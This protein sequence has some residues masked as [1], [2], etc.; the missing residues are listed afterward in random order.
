MSTFYIVEEEEGSSQVAIHAVSPSS[1]TARGAA[2]AAAAGSYIPVDCS[3]L[4]LTFDRCL[5][6]RHSLHTQEGL[7]S[8][9]LFRKQCHHATIQL[10]PCL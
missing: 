7:L 6:L 9:H 4:L 5:P 3:Q 10:F 1:P 8:A 2:A